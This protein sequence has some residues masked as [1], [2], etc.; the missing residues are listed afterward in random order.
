M[1]GKKGQTAVNLSLTNS[2]QAEARECGGI[3]GRQVSHY[4][5]PTLHALVFKMAQTLDEDVLALSGWIRGAWRCLADPSL[6]SFDRR[7]IR[8]YMKDAEIALHTG[9]KQI[10]ER[11]R[12]RREAERL[13]SADRQLDF[14]ILRLD[15]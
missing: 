10:S 7:E 3:V 12:A 9:L 14:R 6:T 5:S 1:R 11:E 2:I 13:V 4:Q 15:A 8:N